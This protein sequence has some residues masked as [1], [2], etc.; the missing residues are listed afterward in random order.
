MCIHVHV[1]LF[2]FNKY[3]IETM[4]LVNCVLNG[5]YIYIVHSNDFIVQYLVW[6]LVDISKK[7]CVGHT[8]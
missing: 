1:Y 2:S 5:L 8:F 3:S 7:Q 6:L 4:H